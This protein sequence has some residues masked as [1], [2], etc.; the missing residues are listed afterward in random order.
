[1]G[2]ATRSGYTRTAAFTYQVDGDERT[3]FV[4]HHDDVY[5][6]VPR[7]DLGRIQGHKRIGRVVR[8]AGFVRVEA[9][10]P[11]FADYPRAMPVTIRKFRRRTE[12]ADW[13]ATK[14]ANRAKA[15][16]NGA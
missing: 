13:L 12:A 5:V 10:P 3:G 15:A 2:R 16:I 4:D 8:F 9:H 7:V 14:W 1:M 11:A 6:I